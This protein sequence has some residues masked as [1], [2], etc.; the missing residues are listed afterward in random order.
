VDS[1]EGSLLAEFERVVEA[2]QCAIEIQEQLRARNEALPEAGRIPFWIGV[3]LG[4]EGI[5]R[6]YGI[7]AQAEK[8]R[9][10]T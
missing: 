7:P 10:L 4:E 3:H 6:D 9:R 5:G 2:V 1:P 8:R